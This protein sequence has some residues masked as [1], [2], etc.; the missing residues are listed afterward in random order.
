M[1]GCLG[2]FCAEKGHESKNPFVDAD[3]DLLIKLAALSQSCGI[4]KIIDIEKFS[5]PFRRGADD[6]R[7]E[8]FDR[9]DRIVHVESIGMGDFAWILKTA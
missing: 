4:S 8:I 5:S 7:S 9:L 6:I 3:H 2:R 1:A